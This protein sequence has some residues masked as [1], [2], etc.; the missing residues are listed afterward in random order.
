MEQITIKIQNTKS[1]RYFARC[2]QI[3][4]ESGCTMGEAM[5]RVTHEDAHNLLDKNPA[6]V[7]IGDAFAVREVLRGRVAEGELDS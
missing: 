2:L 7:E 3:M 4:D 6:P 1:G 5:E